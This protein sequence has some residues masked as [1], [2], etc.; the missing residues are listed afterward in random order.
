ML[1]GGD[2]IGHTQRGNNNAYC[3]DNEISWLGW[4]LNA[5]QRDFLEFVKRVARIWKQHPVLQR[6]RFFQG[7]SIRGSDVKDV[8]WIT[9]N[10]EEMSDQDWTSFVKCLGM[11][12]AGD[13][14]EEVDE[15]GR[16]IEDATVLVLLNAHHETIPF[17]LPPTRKN[18]RW[19]RLFDTSRPHVY[20]VDAP[21]P[22]PLSARS[23]AMFRT[24]V[25]GK[26]ESELISAELAHRLARTSRRR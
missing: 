18:E 25:I 7:R 14:M 24:A 5:E 6:R 9:P 2:E 1:R 20:T 13:L 8:S 15:R 26:P 11:R 16:R 19:E 12:L 22:Y 10:G 3:Q 23:L 4:E 17:K 21:S